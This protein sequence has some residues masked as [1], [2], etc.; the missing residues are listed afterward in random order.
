M[1]PNEALRLIRRYM[2]ELAEAKADLDIAKTND[3]EIEAGHNVGELAVRLIVQ[4]Q[5]LDEWLQ[6]GGFLPEAWDHS[7]YKQLRESARLG[8]T[9][10]PDA[11]W[12]AEP[13]GGPH[14]GVDGHLPEHVDE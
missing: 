3:A 6:D 2:G 9:A 8:R 5:A 12:D 14:P 1:D 13:L 10:M 7:P 11:R 4:V